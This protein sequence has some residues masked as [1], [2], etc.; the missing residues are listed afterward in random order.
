MNTSRARE[1][2]TISMERPTTEMETELGTSTA[3]EPKAT[4]LDPQVSAYVGLV[5]LALGDLS[6]EDVEDLTGG[7]EADLAELAAESDEPLISRLGEPSRYAAELRAAAGFPPAD[8]AAVESKESWWA[9]DRRT[10]REKWTR[11]QADHPWLEKLRPVWWLLR[12]AVLT[13]TLM[14]LAGGHPGLVLLG[15]GA[16]L[17]FWVGLQ[18]DGWGG[19][20][21]RLVT[22]ANIL[23]VLLVLP[24]L[25]DT[26]FGGGYSPSSAYVEVTP[27]EGVF[28]EGEQPSGF[29]VYDGDGQR[30]EGARIFTDQGRPVTVDPWLSDDGT[31]RDVAQ[32][33]I[34]AFPVQSGNLD[35]WNGWKPE[36][37]MH[38][39]TPPSA[40]PPAFP[41]EAATPSD[42]E[43]TTA[44]PTVE[45]S[46]PAVD[47]SDPVDEPAQPTATP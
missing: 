19:W 17:S 32:R 28:V 44:E 40:I 21:T 9:R 12:G 22:W 13:W 2:K 41:I 4:R 3:T 38:E 10:L 30:I 5:R 7:L 26:R 39:W 25:A 11:I 24:F 43:D 14:A 23:A 1:G 27:S 47:S 45:S 35:G 18:Q 15:V 6:V 36:A 16:A 34:D 8:P 37:G 42:P 33:Q 20:S 31:G 46:E 29:F